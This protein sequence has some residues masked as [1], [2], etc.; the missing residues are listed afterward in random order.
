MKLQ[1]RD[2]QIH[3][4]RR[5][6]L[7]GIVN[8]NDDSFC[9]DGTLDL[10]QAL[11]QAADQVNDG[12]D[13]I[14]IGAESART[15]RDA[16]APHEEIQR[17]H[18]FLEA[19]PEKVAALQPRDE[20]QVWPPLLSVNTWRP[21]VVKEVLPLGGDILNDIGGLAEPD[22]AIL[23]AQHQV[24]LLIMHT[25]GLPKQPHF[26]QAYQDIWQSVLAFFDDRLTV[27]KS[28]GLGDAQLILDPGIDFAKQR[29]DNLL[30]FRELNRLVERYDSPVL[31]PISR[32]TVIGEVLDLENPNDRDA[33]TVACLVSGVLRGA[34]LF[35]VH[36]VKTM[37]EALKVLWAIQE[38]PKD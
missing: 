8:I 27:A 12:A 26:N 17:L 32:K 21:E 34:T 16:I 3:F 7:M 38:L 1:A 2:R 22:N 18:P 20:A 19:W 35:R 11:Q 25:V 30:I 37:F 36:H 5:P 10:E 14:D 6:L 23:C 9:Q 13:V 15:N 28:H 33:G 29:D 24:A 4:P 31:L